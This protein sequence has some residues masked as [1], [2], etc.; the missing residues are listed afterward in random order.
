MFVFFFLHQNFVDITFL[1]PQIFCFTWNIFTDSVSK[2]YDFNLI[3][4]NLFFSNI[5]TCKMILFISSFI[6][7]QVFRKVSEYIQ[8]YLFYHFFFFVFI[9]SW[10][11]KAKANQWCFLHTFAPPDKQPWQCACLTEWYYFIFVGL[12]KVWSMLH[13]GLV[14]QDQNENTFLFSS[15][16]DSFCCFSGNF[17]NR[18]LTS[19]K[20]E[21][22]VQNCQWNCMWYT[23]VNINDG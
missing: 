15:F 2:T 7:L 17:R 18:I 14:G 3:K 23:F 4:I 6:D 13:N 8:S 21:L 9:S 16:F 19:Q 5:N 22:L 12:S 10:D 1:L 20:Q 11:L